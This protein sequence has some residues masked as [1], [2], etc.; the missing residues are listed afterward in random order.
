M[1]K[2]FLMA[3]AMLFMTVGQAQNKNKKEPVKVDFYGI[4]FSVV[5]VVGASETDDKFMTAFAAINQLLVVEPKKYDVGKFLQLDVQ[6]LNVDHAISQVDKL[7]NVKF[8]NNKESEMMLKEIVKSYPITKGNA[9]LIVAKKLNKSTN[10]GTFIAVIF[11]GE[12]KHIVSEQ[13]FSGKAKG[14]GLRNFW[15]GA[16]YNGLK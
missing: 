1:K 16:L 9:L 15:A 11:D 10:T 12:T 14:F 5:N 8:R 3:V 7:K 13:E 6:S 2:I 4:D